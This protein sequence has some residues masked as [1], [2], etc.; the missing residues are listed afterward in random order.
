M[1]TRTIAVL[2]RSD[3]TAELMARALPEGWE[4]RVFEDVASIETDALCQAAGVF[5][6]LKSMT[7]ALP[8]KL[9]ESG[10]PVFLD[11]VCETTTTLPDHRGIIRLNGWP[12]FLKHPLLELAAPEER[13][14][15][16]ER[17]LDELGRGFRWVADEP[18]LVT[19][20]ILAMVINEACMAVRE[21]VSVP[22][23]VDTAMRL[24]AAYPGG[25]F[26]WAARIGPE[27][28]VRLLGLLAEKDP[29]YAPC[30]GM[31]EILANK[32]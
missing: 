21:G 27:R 10:T 18:G 1:E 4:W 23:E 19:P 24:G 26:E 8:E 7:A 9:L 31:L 3:R 13:R 25:P 14:P 28:I 6:L 11:A 29:L 32:P 15:N 5:S 22:A 2:G 12:G 30:P 17:L 16:A 20:R